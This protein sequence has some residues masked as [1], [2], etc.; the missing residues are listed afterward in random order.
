MGVSGEESVFVGDSDVDM[1]TGRNAGIDTIGVTWG[2]R[3]RDILDKERP[4]AI[5]DESA[6]LLKIIL[7]K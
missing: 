1:A 6:A 3:T 4:L 7:D 5:V 2:F